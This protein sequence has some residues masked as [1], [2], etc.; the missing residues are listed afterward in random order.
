MS[1]DYAVSLPDR[2]SEPGRLALPAALVVLLVLSAVAL[3]TGRETFGVVGV[4]A[5]AVLSLFYGAVFRP[6]EVV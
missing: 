6:E 3:S 4:I 5:L 2:L 1:R